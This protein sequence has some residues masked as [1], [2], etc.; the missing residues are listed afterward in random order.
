MNL[1]R[2]A[3]TVPLSSVATVVTV[4][5]TYAVLTAEVVV[6]RIILVLEKVNR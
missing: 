3:I 2:P 4:A 1:L 5:A 6:D